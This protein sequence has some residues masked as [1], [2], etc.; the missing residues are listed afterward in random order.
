MGIRAEFKEKGSGAEKLPRFLFY[1]ISKGL[2]MNREVE[3]GVLFAPETEVG[4]PAVVEEHVVHPFVKVAVF[5]VLVIEVNSAHGNQRRVAAFQLN[6]S[7]ADGGSHMELSVSAFPHVE[8][9]YGKSNF[10]SWSCSSLEKPGFIP[11]KI[12]SGMRLASFWNHCSWALMVSPNEYVM[13][14]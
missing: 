5:L 13:T 11:K 12:P 10:I 2:K 4:A 6:I 9:I 8:G 7:L 3:A 1:R 14:A